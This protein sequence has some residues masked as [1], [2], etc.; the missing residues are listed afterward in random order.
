MGKP[1]RRIVS[2]LEWRRR[3]ERKKLTLRALETTRNAAATTDDCLLIT[4]FL[5]EGSHKELDAAR[6]TNGVTAVRRPHPWRP[7]PTTT[8]TGPDL[9][10]LRTPPS[11]ALPP[12]A[13][14]TCSSDKPISGISFLCS[15]KHLRSP[16][17]GSFVARRSSRRNRGPVS[18][19]APGF[20]GCAV[21]W[22]TVQLTPGE[23]ERQ[24]GR[25]LA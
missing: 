7:S 19:A 2:R 13:A 24:A 10:A 6:P 21:S 20:P 3:Y 16:V 22:L 18:F 25:C 12:Q 23:P 8:M 17:L 11:R 4:F 15:S 5:A 1:S 14:A 9:Q